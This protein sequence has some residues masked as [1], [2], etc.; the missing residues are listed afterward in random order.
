MMGI[1]RI[2]AFAACMVLTCSAFAWGGFEHSIV[3]YIA[4]EY[5][6]ENA[7][8][9]IRYYLDQPLTEY[10]EWM[11]HVPTQNT[12]TYKGLIKANHAFTIHKDG[13]IPTESIVDGGACGGTHTMNMI[14]DTLK[15]HKN[16]SD[17]LVVLYMR[18]L[19][20]MFGDLHCPGHIISHYAPGGM[21]PGGSY[22][23]NYQ[24]KKCNYE[25]SPKAMHW[26]WDTAL[27]NEKPGWTF[28]DW[29]VFLDTYTPEQRAQ[30]SQGTFNDWLRECSEDVKVVYEWWQPG[31]NY[32]RTWYDGKVAKYAHDHIRHAG[33]RLAK[34]LND[35]FDYE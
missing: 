31:Q 24:F 19:I 23:N 22:K 17:S 7:E 11:D 18:C 30:V 1:K 10:A 28:E 27:Q 14:I 15:D 2:V 26:M 8:R 25:G 5:L 6:T 13:S 20:H 21:M 12:P 32:D 35:I 34:L 29:R 16:Q 9:N 4:Q 33:Y 3:A